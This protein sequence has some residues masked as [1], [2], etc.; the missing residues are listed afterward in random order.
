[1]VKKLILPSLIAFT[2]L[3]ADTNIEFVTEVSITNLY[4]SILDRSP[5][6][7]GLNYWMNSGLS[8]KEIAA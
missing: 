6:A 1:M 7:D 4:V 2:M 5:R 3:Q 8:N